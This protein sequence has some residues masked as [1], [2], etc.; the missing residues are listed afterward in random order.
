MRRR[1]PFGALGLLVVLVAC[2]GGGPAASQAVK[3]SFVPQTVDFVDDVGLSPSLV[4]DKEGQP[5]LSYL[6]FTHIVTKEEKAHGI[7]PQARP[8]TAPRLPAVL[9]AD[10]IK[11][12]WNRTAAV[13]SSDQANG[14]KVKI[15]RSDQTAIAVDANGVEHVA[16]TQTDGLYYSSDAG[17]TFPDQPTKISG[18]S[19]AGPAIAVD[20]KGVPSVSFYSGASLEF[21]SLQGTKW[22][23]QKVASVRPCGSCPPSRTALD[24]SSGSPVIAYTDAGA[25]T[26]RLATLAGKTWSTQPVGRDGGFSISMAV[27]RQGNPHVAY[28]TTDGTAVVA[29]HSGGGWQHASPGSISATSKAELGGGTALAVDSKGNEYVAWADPSSGVHLNRATGGGFTPIKTAGTTTDGEFPT[30]A[31]TPKDQIVLAWF[32]AKDQDLWLGTYPQGSIGQYAVPSPTPTVAQASAPPAQACAKTD[33]DV[34][35]P[36][37]AANTGFSTTKVSA[38]G[39][40]AFVICFDNA[41]STTHNVAIFKSEQEAA[42]GGAALFTGDIVQGPTRVEYKVNQLQPGSYFFR[43]DVHPTVMTGT[44]SVK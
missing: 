16:W 17:G 11:G 26:P 24:L 31:A 4:V 37:G 34:T 29:T 40:K 18:G 10:Q 32:Q 44:L 14:P 25:R 3:T 9:V 43:C 39:K 8:V 5:H 27:D 38:P 1:L 19:P 33:V 2:G 15:D 20:T 28:F 13:Q 41:D 42:G 21:A 35:A 22:S 23:T 6:G 36:P 7:I 30:M 12:L